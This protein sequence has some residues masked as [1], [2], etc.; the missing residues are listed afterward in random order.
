MTRSNKRQAVRHIRLTI[1]GIILMVIFSIVGIIEMMMLGSKGLVPAAIICAI[2]A[3]IVG[4][5]VHKVIVSSRKR[6]KN[7]YLDIVIERGK[8]RIKLLEKLATGENY[9]YKKCIDF[10]QEHVL[11]YEHLAE[12]SLTINL[13]AT[14]ELREKGKQL[15]SFKDG[16]IT[17]MIEALPRLLALKHLS[18]VVSFYINK[19]KP[20]DQSLIDKIKSI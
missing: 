15:E 5:T 20:I 1:V 11:N 10:Y 9:N 3:F 14:I 13:L 18:D 2:S 16:S 7:R 4:Y 6:L 17:D 8:H 19:G 12:F